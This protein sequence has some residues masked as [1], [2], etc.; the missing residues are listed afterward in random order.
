MILGTII[1][2]V[3]I[4]AGICLINGNWW[5]F[6]SWFLPGLALLQPGG[7]LAAVTASIAASIA[8]IFIIERLIL[9]TNKNRPL[10]RK[11]I[12]SLL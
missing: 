12:N 1:R 3:D 6:T 2:I 4:S 8:I 10:D 11:K 9:K 5:G 7:V